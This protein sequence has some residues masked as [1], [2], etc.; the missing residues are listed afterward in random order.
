[1]G[2][3]D[4]RTAIVS[5]GARGMGASHC[6]AIVAEGGNVVIGD[7]LD[8]EGEALA[9]ELGEAAMY[10]HLDVTDAAAWDGAVAQALERFGGLHVLVNNAG[11][12]VQGAIIEG[13]PEAFR[14]VI[15]I[16]LTG[17]YL[18]MRAAAPAIRDAGGGSIVNISSTAGLMGYAYLS[19]Y[20]ASKWGVRG[21]TK[22]AA[23][24]LGPLGIRVNSVHPG[25]IETPM[26]AGIGDDIV[27]GQPI[28][29]FGKPEE[30]AQLVC[31]LASDDS[32]YSTGSEFVVDGG[33][34]TGSVIASLEG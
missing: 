22:V 8:D 17:V 28:G 9:A 30:V 18:G 2:R 26:T 29:R 12:L 1:M 25:P 11:V 31:F 13:D 34:T 21:L 4:G 7:I 10:V 3:F 24:E 6:R 23:L 19:G 5:G 27:G 14:R 15:D 16:N 20:A 32:S 33:Q